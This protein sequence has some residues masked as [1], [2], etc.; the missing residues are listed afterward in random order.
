MKNTG[1]GK[2]A[3]AAIAVDRTAR[4]AGDAS[5]RARGTAGGIAARDVE[6]RLARRVNRA[7]MLGGYIEHWFALPTNRSFATESVASLWTWPATRSR[8]SAWL[9][10]TSARPSV[11]CHVAARP[12]RMQTRSRSPGA[13]MPSASAQPGRGSGPAGSG[14][15]ASLYEP[16]T[17]RGVSP[18]PGTVWSCRSACP[19]SRTTSRSAP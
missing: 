10:T 18:P 6:L 19:C 16:T 17:S 7:A 5:H 11:S 9:R 2:S 8:G 13:T 14:G 4:P 15:R 12:H 1:S 3:Y